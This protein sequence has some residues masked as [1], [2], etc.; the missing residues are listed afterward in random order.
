MMSDLWIR[1]R[2]LF[3][4]KSVE[5]ELDDEL[6]FHFEQQA[7]KY[8][9]AGM[10]RE[11]ALRRARLEFGG[12]DQVKEE[13]RDARGVR[14]LETL[15][16]D[17]RYSLRM[18]RKSPGFSFVAVLTLALGIGASSA[19]FSILE[20]QLWRSLPFP[21]AERLMDVHLALRSNPKQWDVLGIGAFRAWQEQSRSFTGLSGYLYTEE[22]NFTANGTSERANVMAV[23]SDIFSTL[24]LSPM[25]G[26][27]FL[28]EEEMAGRDHVAILS[29]SLW[30]DRFLSDP[31]VLGKSIAIDG[32]SYTVVGIASDVLRFEY[33]DEPEIFVP[34]DL[35][36]PAEALRDVYVV[37]RLA[38]HVSA[39]RAGEELTAILEREQKSEG[40]PLEDVAAVEGLRETWTGFAARP[41]RFFAGAVA[42]V[43]LIACVNTAGLLLARGLARQ[44]EFAL[45]AALG[46]GRSRIAGQ[47]LVE[48]AMMA[49]LGGASGALAGVWLARWFVV[50]LPEDALPRHT[51]ISLDARVLLFALLAS[52]L[53]ALLVGLAPAVFAGRGDL[54]DALRQNAPGRS[55]ARPQLRARRLLVALELALGLVLLFGAGLF[56]STFVRLEQAP[57]GFE[58]PG[59]LSFEVALRGGRYAKLDQVERYF[60]QLTDRLRSLPGAR[61]VTLGSGLPLTGTTGFFAQLKVAGR[62]AIGRWGTHTIV[63]SI[64][65][66]Y[67]RALH[68]HLLAGRSFGPQDTESSPQVAILNRNAARTLFGRADPLGKVLEFLSDEK[69]G[70]PAA[71]PV[72]VIGVA[73]NTQEFGA[74]EVPFDVMY[75]PFAQHPVPSAFLLVDSALPRGA[76]A[77]V[78]RSAT[79]GL[80]K[81]QPVFDMRTM[82]DRV[83]DSLR[84]ARFNLFLVGALASLG[85][86]LVSVGVF[87][88]VAY[89]V[90][91]RTQEFGIRLALGARPLEILR[92]AIGQSLRMGAV[93]LALGVAW[94]LILG[95][96]LRHTLYLAPH[97]HSGML[98]GVNIYD[99]YVLAGACALLTLAL[100]LASYVPARRAMRVDPMVA[101]RY[102]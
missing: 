44:R 65:P 89:F 7:L 52:F 84:G 69:R 14:L 51:E 96:L 29:H 73:E 68:I 97:E 38:R 54:H 12:L 46:A 88:T 42:L 37:G 90:R 43:L 13:C 4:H 79:Y 30:R 93:G 28:P 9:R 60:D 61:E 19:I 64:A 55:A 56:T 40:V 49:V 26:R 53:S 75:L 74:D 6:R 94:S 62:P 101:L 34:L 67:F 16:Q 15:A 83:D 47:V 102:E 39:E 58:A 78:I 23:T 57:R 24:G 48:T 17:T 31:A 86:V 95:H 92:Q 59:A 87:G 33:I 76:L 41:L 1:L 36:Q 98:Y 20:A 45:R 18:L 71:P 81:D 70:V 3:R 66:N 35:E 2:A 8:A 5:R 80:D 21:D 91:Q 85:I 63:H 100:L 32:A 25:R 22:R 27:A 50:F 72:E 11:E 77:G 99:P 10:T 82:D